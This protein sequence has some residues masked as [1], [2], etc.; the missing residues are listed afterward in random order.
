MHESNG[1]QRVRLSLSKELFRS[2]GVLHKNKC[3]AVWLIIATA[4]I[5]LV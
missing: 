5:D 4:K 2:L 3:L 1:K